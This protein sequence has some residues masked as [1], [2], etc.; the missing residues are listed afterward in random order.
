MEN[1]NLMAEEELVLRRNA[2]KIIADLP[3]NLESLPP[4]KISKILHELRLHQIELEMQNEELRRVQQEKDKLSKLYFD[5]YD[6][7][8]VGYL[9]IS[10]EG[11]IIE[12]NLT[13]ATMLC[14]NRSKLIGQP[15]AKFIFSEDQDTYYLKHRKPLLN[16]CDPQICELRILKPDGTTFWANLKATVT[17]EMLASSPPPPQ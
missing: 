2:E 11:L 4:L 8:P 12:G 3:E 5:L 7:A 1:K 16:A 17:Q 13:A 14:M 6:L 15:I 10:E 9:T